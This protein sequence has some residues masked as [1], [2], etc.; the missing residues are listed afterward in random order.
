MKSTA[1]K[2]FCF[3]AAMMAAP[4]ACKAVQ[5]TLPYE[6][7]HALFGALTKVKSGLTPA[8]VGLAATDV[9]ALKGAAEAFEEAAQK[10][11]FQSERAKSAKDPITAQEQSSDDWLKFRHGTITLEL[12][13][14]NLPFTDDE[15][16]TSELTPDI[17][18]LIQHYLSAPA[19]KK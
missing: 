13:M 7:A 3:V 10:F 17:Y 8:N 12:Q 14:L 4:L 1:I 6:D 19:A 5:V 2:V 11:Q 15:I 16:K 18:A 9:F